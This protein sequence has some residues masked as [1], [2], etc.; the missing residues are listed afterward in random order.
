MNCG[1]TD[2]VIAVRPEAVASSSDLN[3]DRLA[4]SSAAGL[5]SAI[6]P[7]R[8]ISGSGRYVPQVITMPGAT[9]R[10]MNLC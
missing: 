8:A 10:H 1:G 5:Q 6:N 7:A 9:S 3:F 2:V 4:Q